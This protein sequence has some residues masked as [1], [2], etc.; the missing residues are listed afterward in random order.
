MALPFSPK[1]QDQPRRSSRRSHTTS[2]VEESVPSASTA[3]PSS[4]RR[5]K[6]DN[7]DPDE[8]A[9]GFSNGNTS[10]GT[11]GTSSR[12]SRRSN[13][14]GR[15]NGKGAPEEPPAAS[16][17]I[18]QEVEEEDEEEQ[19]ATRCV[20]GSE[21]SLPLLSFQ[22]S[23]LFFNIIIIL[24]P[25]CTS[26]HHHGLFLHHPARHLV[27]HSSPSTLIHH[28]IFYPISLLGYA[29]LTGMH[30]HAGLRG[31]QLLRILSTLAYL[32]VPIPPYPSPYRASF[33]FLS[34]RHII[35]HCFSFLRSS[36]I[37]A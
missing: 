24:P 1:D 8:G 36:Y 18:P 31:D 16:P 17:P 3:P 6:T 32:V 2:P 33:T 5:P 13:K 26:F 37:G 11:N 27:P 30:W 14:N 23:N 25:T 35:I 10:G 28:P 12:Q 19:G 7:M 9:G 22:P 20:C 4:K 29:W 15:S 21:Y 34:T